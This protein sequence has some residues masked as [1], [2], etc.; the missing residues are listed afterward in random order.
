M[1]MR[2]FLLFITLTSVVFCSNAQTEKTNNGHFVICYDKDVESYAMASG[3]ILNLVWDRLDEF[4]FK[5]PKKVVFNLVKSERN[6]LFLHKDKPIITLEYI[7]LD[8]SKV[9]VNFVYGLCHEMGHVCMFHITPNKNNWMSL[10]YR[11]GWADIFG[12]SMTILLDEKFG[13]DAWPN[14]YNYLE[15]LAVYTNMRTQAFEKGDDVSASYI[16]DFFWKKLVEEKGMDKM[17][18]FFRQ[19]KSNRVRNPDADKKFRAELVKFGVTDDLLDYFDQ[20]KQ[21]LI[22]SE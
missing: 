12:E 21:H 5:P 6:R 10:P 22:L 9:P 3:N 8:P 15:R 2:N 14:P 13:V 11:E 4:G 7:S 19:I 1:A 17:P 18:F 20:N 16:S